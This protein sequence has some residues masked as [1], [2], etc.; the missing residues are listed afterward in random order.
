MNK[1][2]TIFISMP[3]QDDK[4]TAYAIDH[5]FA[6]A[7]HPENIFI[8]IALTCMS[9]KYLKEIKKRM[10]DNPNIRLDYKKQKRNDID[11]LGIGQGRTRAA[12]LYKNEDY[13]L[14]IDCHSYL[15]KNWDTKLISYFNESKEIVKKKNLV[16]SCI[17]PIYFYDKNENVVKENNPKTRYGTYV[18]GDFFVNVVP[19]WAEVD[20]LDINK[21]NFIP[22]HKLNPACVFGDKNFANDP[23]VWEKATFYDEDWTQ[24]LNLFDRDF[25]F[26]FPN[27]ENFPVRHL[28]GDLETK[29]HSRL[30]FTEY[31]SKNKVKEIHQKLIKNYKEFVNDPKNQNAINKY[32]NYSKADAKMGYF[33]PLKNFVPE[34]F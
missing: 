31:L 5:A 25:A 15:D 21:N 19:R 4:E 29:K 11:T 14:Q 7:D 27:F 33:F 20:I 12:K 10:K 34:G 16:I 1:T 26:V 24:Q 17:P 3:S 9:T 22:A 18:V 28:D 13:M 30:F 23:G 8:G 6:N 32:R 2:S